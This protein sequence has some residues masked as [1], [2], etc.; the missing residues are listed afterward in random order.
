M[1]GDFS[2]NHYPGVSTG[3]V[4]RQAKLLLLLPCSVSLQLFTNTAAAL[5]CEVRA[6]TADGGVCSPTQ[7]QR[8]AAQ[9]S[10]ISRGEALFRRRVAAQRSAPDG[11]REA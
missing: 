11:G 1:C 4:L 8:E 5:P 3:P 10:L 7:V 9:W 2:L 6:R